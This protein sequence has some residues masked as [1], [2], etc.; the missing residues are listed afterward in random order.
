MISDWAHKPNPGLKPGFL[1]LKWVGFFGLKTRVPRFLIFSQFEA[2][3]TQKMSV[4]ETFFTYFHDF[5]ISSHLI[6]NK[7]CYKQIIFYIEIVLHFT[8]YQSA[9]ET[10]TI[11]FLWLVW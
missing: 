3:K 6:S 4:F 7:E 8:K 11:K 5:L 2:K 9:S 1:P 10:A